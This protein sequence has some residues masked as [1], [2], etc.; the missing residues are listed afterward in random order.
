MGTVFDIKTS[1]VGLTCPASKTKG[2]FAG[3]SLEGSVI[4]ERKDANSKF[5]GGQV[6]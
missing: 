5:Y 4:I 2:L 1:N 3:V 6:S